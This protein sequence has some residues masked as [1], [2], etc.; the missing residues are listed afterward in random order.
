MK[1]LTARDVMNADVLSVTPDL[2]VHELAVFLVEHQI[3]GA[4]VLD[5]RG[6]L[7]GLVSLTDIAEGD[8]LR[9]DARDAEAPR[10]RRRR[11]ED[12]A[13]LR[14]QT[15]DLLVKDIMTPTVYSVEPDTPVAELARTMIAGRIHRLLVTEQGRVAGIVTSLDLLSL[16]VAPEPTKVSRRP[17][18]VRGKGAALVALVALAAATGCSRSGP[19]SAAAATTAPVTTTLPASS[20][21]PGHPPL[22]SSP[23]AMPAGH[24]AIG[25]G[26]T[27]GE[28]VRGTV[29][30]APALRERAPKGVALFL[31]A[32][33]A[34]KRI[35][36]VRKQEPVM[37]PFTF[38]LSGQDAMTDGSDWSGTLEITARLSGSGDAAPA[39]GDVEG[40]VSGVAVGAKDVRIVL[41]T[42]RP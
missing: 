40:R 25:E 22:A 6:H 14:V 27:A 42:V 28:P 32:R 21:P 19:D 8:A 9:E 39:P 38:E 4:P 15:T 18:R 29:T 11:G 26:V 36:A 1:P 41:D 5:H 34:D 10:G 35:V 23:A 24:P 17:A 37:F 33:A 3:S 31:I 2:T 16:L 20:L 13:G 7:V 30:L 12:I